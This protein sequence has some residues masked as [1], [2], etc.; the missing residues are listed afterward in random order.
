M[1]N[2]DMPGE[3][4]KGRELGRSMSETSS[5]SAILYLFF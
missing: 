4:M 2:N 3:K 5:I 1:Q